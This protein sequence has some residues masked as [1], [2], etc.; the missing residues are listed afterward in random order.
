MTGSG[1]P[2]R[3]RSPARSLP[4][5]VGAVFALLGAVGCAGGSSSTPAV[6]TSTAA[7]GNSTTSATPSNPTPSSPAAPPSVPRAKPGAVAIESR[8]FRDPI[9]S[10]PHNNGPPTA[11]RT[12]ITRLWV[13]SSPNLRPLILLAHGLAGE[14]D[15][16][17]QLATS[18]A[19]A[20]FVVAAPRFPAS[21]ESGG[22]GVAGTSDLVEQPADMILVLDGLL[23][24][25]DL[26]IDSDRVGVTGL[27]LG[28]STV[29]ALSTDTCCIDPRIK[30]AAILDGLRPG[31]M[32]GGRLVPNRIPVMLMHCDKDYSLAYAA[33]AV[34]GF[35]RMVAPAWL[36]TMR[37]A[38][39]AEPYQSSPSDMDSLVEQVTLDFWQG[40][41]GQ[42]SGALD[43]ITTDI[44]GDDRATV[45]HKG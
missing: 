29:Y 32:P 35:A 38:Q 34:P 1:P 25:K 9:R 3:R 4:V 7:E 45:E 44:D 23:A 15:K 14:P 28:G 43:R 33:H 22:A 36:V 20:G 30:S 13:P 31:A 2:S 17:D 11:G 18:W 40:T 10:T 8:T 27:S 6:A 5:A 16:F 26:R 24:E 21:S 39:H 12:L 19:A 42:D 41:L 37:C